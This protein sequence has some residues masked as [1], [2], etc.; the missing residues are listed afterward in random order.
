LAGFAVLELDLIRVKGKTVPVRIFTLHGGPEAA[1]GEDFKAL[2]ARHAAML[3]AYRRRR[4][5]ETAA[6]LGDC[7]RLEPRLH[8]LYDLYSDRLAAFRAA[9]PGPDWDGVFTATSK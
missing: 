8:K 6:A 5:D 2:A 4:W 7:R 3:D 1:S 9:S